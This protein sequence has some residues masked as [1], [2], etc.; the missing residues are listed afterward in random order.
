MTNKKYFYVYM[1]DTT[2]IFAYVG[3]ALGALSTLYAVINH[4]RVRSTC[5]G[6]KAEVSLDIESTT[7]QTKP[8]P[9]AE[10]V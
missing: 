4:K 2:S 6:M 9:P 7:P 10:S 3:T 5:C 1:S 8:V